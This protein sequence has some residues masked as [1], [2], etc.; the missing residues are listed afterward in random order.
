MKWVAQLKKGAS[1]FRPPEY[2]S[3]EL[4]AEKYRSVNQSSISILADC[5][6]HNTV[7][8]HL[9]RGNEIICLLCLNVVSDCIMT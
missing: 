2:L 9:H 7:G 5:A 8:R 4:K 3:M 6:V 1:A